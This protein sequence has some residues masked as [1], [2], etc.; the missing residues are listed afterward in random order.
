MGEA[1][2]QEKEHV[3]CWLPFPEPT[4]IIETIQKKHPNVDFTYKQLEY[5]KEGKNWEVKEIPDGQNFT[6]P[7]AY[8][9]ANHQ[10][11]LY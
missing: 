9:S 11:R 6:P 4:E 7:S 1:P 5:K 10:S 8:T 2:P 3:L